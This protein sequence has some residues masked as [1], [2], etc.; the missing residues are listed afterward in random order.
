MAS[1]MKE[2]LQEGKKLN[3]YGGGLFNKTDIRL[4]NLI[5]VYEAVLENIGSPVFITDTDRNLV[6]I[7]KVCLEFMGIKDVAPFLGKKCADVYK[8][9]ICKNNCPLVECMDETKRITRKAIII[10]TDGNPIHL[11]VDASPIVDRDGELLGGMEVLFD[12]TDE[13]ELKDRMKDETEYSNSIIHGIRDPFFIVN[14]DMVVT[15]INREA[16]QMAG[17]TVAEIINAKKCTDVFRTPLCHGNCP[18]KQTFATGQP[19]VEVRNKMKNQ[20]GDEIELLINASPIKN[21]RGEVVGGS[22]MIRDISKYAIEDEVKKYVMELIESC[23]SLAANSQETTVTS[24][25]MNRG[26]A[27]LAE[28]SSQVAE[29]SSETGKQAEDGSNAISQ[30]L[31][32]MNEIYEV[33]QK[34]KDSLAE[35]AHHSEK[36]G[37]IISVIDD[38]AEQ[39]NLLAL[40]AAI[41]A[42]RAGEHGKGFAVVADEVRK[43]AERSAQSSKEIANL[44]FSSQKSTEKTNE[45]VSETLN[46]VESIKNGASEANNRLEEIVSGIRNVNDHFSNISAATE[47]ISASAEQVSA[48]AENVSKL[49]DRLLRVAQ[50]LQETADKLGE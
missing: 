46:I 41:E 30:T 20:Q 36:M 1:N 9:D 39:T 7:N 33:V 18:I 44:I 43:L 13:I 17:Y 21:A 19:V 25:Q 34:V 35:I 45:I 50:G 47:E 32:E 29:L 38:V 14:R 49:A 22:E 4:V 6:Y 10:D 5:K 15:Y 28:D 37:E 23:E 26:I 31:N 24:E 11:S 27:S 3:I 42:A 40:N 16:A 8:A 12:I 48:A 2:A